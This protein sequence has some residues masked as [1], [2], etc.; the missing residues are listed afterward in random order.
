MNLSDV[1][2]SRDIN[3]DMTTY[4]EKYSYRVCVCVRVR[5]RMLA[6]FVCTTDKI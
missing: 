2:S 5:A 3:V 6:R 4:F 1:K